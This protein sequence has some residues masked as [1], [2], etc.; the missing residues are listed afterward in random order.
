MIL[1]EKM[2][3]FFITGF[4]FLLDIVRGLRL[5]Q[6]PHKFLSSVFLL[7][8][9][10]CIS[11]SPSL[12][13]LI[14]VVHASLLSVPPLYTTTTTTNLNWKANSYSWQML[15]PGLSIW[16]CSTECQNECETNLHTSETCQLAGYT[17]CLFLILLCPL[18]SATL[19]PTVFFVN[20]LST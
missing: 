6:M 18:Q 20:N 16:I 12:F 17:A 15:T 2:S 4:T 9:Q 19:H 13:L 1:L 3:T 7:Q 8:Y 10:L 11:G 5:M 14:V